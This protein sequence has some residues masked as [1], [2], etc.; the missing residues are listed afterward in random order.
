MKTSYTYIV[1]RYI[2]DTTA[3]EFV[4]VGVALYAPQS[5]FLSAVCRSTYGRLTRIF[6][7]VD[8]EAFKSLMRYVQSSFETRGAKLND[9][10]ALD[11]QPT[12]VIE[13]AH[14]I[15]PR[16]DSSLQWSDMG[17]GLTENPS[18]TLEKLFERLV[19]AH[20]Q[21]ARPSG[22]DDQTVWKKYRQDLEQRH[23]LSKLQPKTIVSARRD[24]E[25][26]FEHAWKNQQWHC[27]EAVS[28]DLLEPESIRHK[29]HQWL[30]RVSSIQDS[31][32]QFKVYLLLGEPQLERL[33]PAFAK[34]ENILNKIP[35]EKEFVR[36]HESASF[37]GHL[38]DAIQRHNEETG[39][40]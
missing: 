11:G 17:S 36:E 6:P 29:A 34:A 8:G 12:S 20:E 16:D 21:S 22:R 31:P 25:L 2:H 24:D 1:L 35:V 18:A 40:T 7:G 5:R 9:E 27:F 30:G 14:A 3:A 19:E 13:I 4:N 33:K 26:E 32:E 38:A 23:V 28:F 39:A 37:A 10:L 15:V